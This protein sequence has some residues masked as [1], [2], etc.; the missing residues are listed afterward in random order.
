LALRSTIAVWPTAIPG[1]RRLPLLGV[2]AVRRA[3]LEVFIHG[4]KC[5]VTLRTPQRFW[6]F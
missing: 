2:E 4:R 1:A 3:G 5:Q 6:F